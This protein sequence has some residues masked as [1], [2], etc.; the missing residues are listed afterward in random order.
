MV[1]EAAAAAELQ[2]AL[3]LQPAGAAGGDAAA[4]GADAAAAAEAAL[5]PGAPSPFMA[6][7]TLLS[8]HMW[9][10]LRRLRAEGEG[11]KDFRQVR[12]CVCVG[13]FC[14]FGGVLFSLP[15][16]LPILLNPLNSSPKP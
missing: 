4:G 8:L 2:A 13:V 6:H 11:A 16:P 5:L 1:K 3:C 7:H 10:L 15:R 12:V 14:F 9:L